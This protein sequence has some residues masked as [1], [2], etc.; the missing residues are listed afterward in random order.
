MKK[1]ENFSKEEIENFIKESRSYRDLALKLGYSN[2]SGSAI[3]TIKS[4]I[5]ELNLDVSHFT[6]Q[7]WNKNNFDYSRFQYGKKIRGAT[8][9][10]ALT[11]LRGWRCENCGLTEWQGQK[12]PL[13][14]HHIDGD[15]LNSVL[16]NLQVLCP[17]CHALTNNY[18]GKNQ[19]KQDGL[20]VS[21]E[22][23]VEALREAPNIRQAL[24]RVGLTAK[25]ANYTRA[26]E[27]IIKYQIEKHLKK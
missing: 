4:M 17:N 25:G 15:E 6:G 23:L 11:A 22:A 24:L 21:E 16:E 13:E 8:M 14:V 27:L 1:W 20:K 18:K 9:I 2:E 12:V 10:Q 19:K 5:Q 3:A 26:N 7:G